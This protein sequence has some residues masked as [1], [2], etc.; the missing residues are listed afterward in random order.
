MTKVI[1]FS[2]FGKNPKY[3][4][5]AVEN[6]RRIATVLPEWQ[7]LFYCGE[8]V[9]LR[10]R[11]EIEQLGGQVVLTD[12][13]E[14]QSATLWRI[15]AVLS[16]EVEV[17]IL[18][19]ADSLISSREASLVTR[20]A[21]TDKEI[22]VIRDHPEH[23]WHMPAGLVGLRRTPRVVSAVEDRLRKPYHPYYGVDADFLYLHLWRNRSITRHIDDSFL[24]TYTFSR[25]LRSVIMNPDYCGRVAFDSNGDR[26]PEEPESAVGLS[27]AL[28]R[29]FF[30][31]KWKRVMESIRVVVNP[32]LIS[33]GNLT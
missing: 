5:G 14:T 31:R 3:L 15:A 29:W 20:W 19:D 26:L 33:G 7:P 12:K 24:L 22:H 4:I 13:E 23:I 9:P 8:S 11:N 28:F 25:R 1:S 2:L 27:S 17:C 18:R 21:E 6:C 16:P 10:V 32:R 30:V